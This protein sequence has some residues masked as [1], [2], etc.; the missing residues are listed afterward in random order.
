MLKLYS[1]LYFSKTPEDLESLATEISN[2]Y[3][4]QTKT[5]RPQIL[6]FS[7]HQAMTTFDLQTILS[8]SYF[9][10]LLHDH[11]LYID[12]LSSVLSLFFS[13]ISKLSLKW[14]C[15][16]IASHTLYMFPVRTTIANILK[17]FG[18]PNNLLNH[19]I[20]VVMSS[21]H[22][23][24]THIASDSQKMNIAHITAQT[25]FVSLTTY[26]QS[27]IVKT[28]H[29]VIPIFPQH[30]LYSFMP[31][32]FG[33]FVHRIESLGF[34][35][36]FEGYF[37]SFIQN[38]AR[39]FHKKLPPLPDDYHIPLPLTC[40]ICK[41]LLND[42]KE[43]LGFFFCSACI[44]KWFK[45]SRTPIHP[46]TGEKISQDAIRSSVLMSEVTYRFKLLALKQ[47]GYP[48]NYHYESQE[49]ELP[50]PQ[51]LQPDQQNL[52]NHDNHHLNG[53][54]I[55]ENTLLEFLRDIEDI[56]ESNEEEEEEEERGENNENI[57]AYIDNFEV[58]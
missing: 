37:E 44:S 7:Q 11:A 15:K 9:N 53:E 39:L 38:I 47:L 21:F 48:D 33:S 43:S 27:R 36:T 50:P 19:A 55:L 58:D 32:L 26:L 30:I 52:Q 10:G 8:T 23:V 5:T 6:N 46:M 24:G 57:D 20:N 45:S 28:I 29:S 2:F 31:L 25:V 18:C 34:S 49:I 56:M 13:P 17:S 16:Y 1:R 4:A 22:V 41:E 12:S 51:N 3:K 42:P 54:I 40:I 14:R 35:A